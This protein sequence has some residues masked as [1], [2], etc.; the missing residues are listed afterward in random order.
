L[1]VAAD[2]AMGTKQVLLF[3]PKMPG[4]EAV[5]RILVCATGVE[6]ATIRTTHGMTTSEWSRLFVAANDSQALGLL[7]DD[8]PRL[9]PK[10]LLREAR[11]LAKDDDLGTIVIDDLA[12]FDLGCGA[13]RPAKLRCLGQMAAEL[14]VA[15]LVGTSRPLRPAA[16]PHGFTLRTLSTSREGRRA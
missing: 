11:R 1:A 3:T 7:I 12:R 8:R 14:G 13:D 5:R 4:L 6:L 9:T 16:R 2:L 10:R 15:I